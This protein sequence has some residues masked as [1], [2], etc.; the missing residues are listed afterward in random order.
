MEELTITLHCTIVHLLLH[1][2]SSSPSVLARYYRVISKKWWE[3]VYRKETFGPVILNITNFSDPFFF[4]D[5][6][7][8]MELQF[9]FEDKE[10]WNRIQNRLPWQKFLSRFIN[11]VSV[12]LPRLGP[13]MQYF[14]NEK[15]TGP[16]SLSVWS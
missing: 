1:D 11:P 14:V 16:R 6:Y 7:H 8:D 9:V 2:S 5:V 13:L 4:P 10:E 3:L 12:H 15:R